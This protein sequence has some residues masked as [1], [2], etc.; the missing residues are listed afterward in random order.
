MS[1][2]PLWKTQ[3]YLTPHLP[4]LPASIYANN[5]CTRMHPYDATHTL[6]LIIWM[7]PVCLCIFLFVKG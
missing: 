6:I 3:S 7:A 2:Q 4:P 1:R 5:T